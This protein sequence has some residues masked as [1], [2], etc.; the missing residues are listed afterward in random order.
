MN[1]SQ[2]ER[3]LT[4][5]ERLLA[6]K[7]DDWCAIRRVWRPLID[8]GDLESRVCFA[9]LILWYINAPEPVN[10]RARE[11]LQEA[12]KAGHADAMY[13]IAK[14]GH[15]IGQE[16]DELLIR[17]AELGSRGAQRD[18]GALYST[19]DWTGPKDPARGFYWYRLAAERGHSDAQYNLGFMYILGE[20]T[21]ADVDEGL[22]WIH[23]A[24]MQGDWSARRLLADL[25]RNGYYGVPRRIGEA[26]RWE[27]LQ[28]VVELKQRGKSR[29]IQLDELRESD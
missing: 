13:W 8:Q 23:R 4:L 15:A 12:A 24:A 21:E 16:A 7:R 22:Q 27:H 18:L 9:V 5:T 29:R 10:D 1:A 6:K 14:R 11:Y 2:K 20:G 26:E 28:S 17:A 19:G 25:Y 3:L